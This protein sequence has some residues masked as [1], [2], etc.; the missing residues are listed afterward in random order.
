MSVCL[1]A[2]DVLRQAVRQVRVQPSSQP[3]ASDPRGLEERLVMRKKNKSGKLVGGLEF[4]VSCPGCG[5]CTLHIDDKYYLWCE[6]PKCKFYQRRFKVPWPAKVRR[7]ILGKQN[8]FERAMKE[9][10]QS[11]REVRVLA[12]QKKSSGVYICPI[13]PELITEKVVEHLPCQKRGKK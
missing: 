12:K 7:Y 5:T 1:F 9:V 11:K 2:S 10:G 8:D 6:N 4:N 3:L 13:Y